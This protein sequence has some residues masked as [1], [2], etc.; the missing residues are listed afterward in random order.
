VVLDPSVPS[1]DG[2]CHLFRM[3][4]EIRNRI[5]E[6]ALSFGGEGL[7]VREDVDIRTPVYVKEVEIDSL[8]WERREAEL[9]ERIRHF[10]EVASPNEP[11][12]YIRPDDVE[13]ANQL[14]YV[15]RQLY[16]ETKG[17]ALLFNDLVFIRRNSDDR[18]AELG[19]ARFLWHCSRAWKN[20]IRTIV[21]RDA[22][23]RLGGW[24]PPAA[25]E[26]T[27]FVVIRDD[28][29][30]KAREHDLDAIANFLNQHPKANLKHFIKYANN[31]NWTSSFLAPLAIQLMFRGQYSPLGNTAG[32]MRLFVDPNNK[33]YKE[34]MFYIMRDRLVIDRQMG[35]LTNYRAYFHDKDFDEDWFRLQMNTNAEIASG[36]L[37]YTPNAIEVWT[38][39]IKKWYAEG[40]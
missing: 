19:C 36:V 10:M 12:L 18:T 31:D 16:K 13:E 28:E 7:Y 35:H 34:L 20:G 6:F 5:N 37:P 15:C 21:V 23:K 9:D 22:E 25:S 3:P 1:S 2:T 38:A 4:A 26:S 27:S 14:K 40:F 30:V 11:K 24:I 8:T 29:R 17:V 32:L 33:V 39:E